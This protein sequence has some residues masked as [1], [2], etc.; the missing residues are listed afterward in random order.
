MDNLEKNYHDEKEVK[1]TEENCN[2][3]EK[4]SESDNCQAETKNNFV[5]ALITRLDLKGEWNVQKIFNIF[6]TCYPFILIILIIQ[7]IFVVNINGFGLNKK[8][9]FGLFDVFSVKAYA[10]LLS[11]IKNISLTYGDSYKKIVSFL[12]AALVYTFISFLIAIITVTVMQIR[13]IFVKKKPFVSV[14]YFIL[15]AALSLGVVLVAK[16][17]EFIA[18][19]AL[20]NS[21]WGVSIT[22]RATPAV[23]LIMALGVA[24]TVLKYLA[25]PLSKRNDTKNQ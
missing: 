23:I 7:K 12:T 5:D 10:S 3:F 14:P 13:E 18:V 24:G 4:S 11:Y 9:S 1:E 19:T 21:F 15:P 6:N 2:K 20:Y 22:F 25:N 8:V 17:L 16:T